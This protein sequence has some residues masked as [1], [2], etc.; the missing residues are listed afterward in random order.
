M[1]SFFCLQPI[2]PY[3]PYSVG[4]IVCRMGGGDAKARPCPQLLR[5][6]CSS[7]MTS[8]RCLLRW[9]KGNVQR[10]LCRSP[11]RIQGASVFARSGEQA[12]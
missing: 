2:L 12:A 10:G 7:Y 11:V 1:C 6:L 9:V 3:L 4:R 5:W 8:C